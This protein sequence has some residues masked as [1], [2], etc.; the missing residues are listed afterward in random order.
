MSRSRIRCSRRTPSGRR[1][2]SV[3]QQTEGPPKDGT[4][5]ESVS[6]IGE[7]RSP[8]GIRKTLNH[9]KT[10]ID[11]FRKALELTELISE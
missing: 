1:D 6:R 10:A 11:N 7:L 4:R 2:L 3:K 5:R 8:W 9:F